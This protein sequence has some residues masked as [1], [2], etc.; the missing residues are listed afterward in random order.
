MVHSLCPSIY[1]HEIVK[2]GLILSLF[3]GNV[4]HFELRENI[5]I[6]VVGDPGL[7]KSQMLQACARIAAKGIINGWKIFYLTYGHIKEF[8]TW[9]LKV[10]MYA[11]IQVHHPVWQ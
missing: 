8:I 6:L 4:E 5:H 7:G 1:G 3:G 2:A 11:E 10:Y 9:F